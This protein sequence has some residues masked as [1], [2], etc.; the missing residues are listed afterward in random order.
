[1]SVA[2]VGSPFWLRILFTATSAPVLSH[3]TGEL[4]CA[5]SYFAQAI[6][7]L[8][9]RGSCSWGMTICRALLRV[10]LLVSCGKYGELQLA[11]TCFAPSYWGITISKLLSSVAL[12]GNYNSQGLALRQAT[13]EFHWG[14]K[15]CRGDSGNTPRLLANPVH[16]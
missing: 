16:H 8:Q 10:K 11:R 6:G 1:M 15:I 14:L 7:G 5:G 9:F 12:V 2:N 13:G 4:Q 3:A